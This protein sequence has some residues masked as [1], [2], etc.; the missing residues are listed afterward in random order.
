MSKVAGSRTSQSSR[1]ARSRTSTSRQENGPSKQINALSGKVNI[2]G[3]RMGVRPKQSETVII[4]SVDDRREKAKLARTKLMGQFPIVNPSSTVI[5]YMS[6]EELE[7]DEYPEITIANILN[8]AGIENI[9]LA[10]S[11]YDPLMGPYERSKRCQT[12]DAYGTDCPYHPGKILFKRPN[13]KGELIS[14]PIYRTTFLTELARCLNCICQTCGLLRLP[15]EIAEKIGLMQYSGSTRLA[16]YAETSVKIKVCQRQDTKCLVTGEYKVLKKE[17][18]VRERFSD[19]QVETVF[20]YEAYNILRHLPDE[21]A[22]A[23]GFSPY[24]KPR[25]IYILWGIPVIPPLIRPVRTIQGDKP[26][27]DDFT[28]RYAG[29]LKA[30]TELRNIAPEKVEEIY[31]DARKKRY[32]GELDHHPDI[33]AFFFN[34]TKSLAEQVDGL[35]SEKSTTGTN[36]IKANLHTTLDKKEGFI[37]YHLAGGNVIHSARTVIGPGSKMHVWEIG[38][39]EEI[40]MHLTVEEQVTDISIN[41]L[42]RWLEEGNVRSVIRDG[43]TTQILSNNRSGASKF[44]LQIGDVAYRR[45]MNGDPVPMNRNPSLHKQSMMVLYVRIIPGRKTFALPLVTTPG[46][47]ADF[48]GDEMNLHVPQSQEARAEM[49]LMSVA[50]SLE[51]V[52]KGG[53]IIGLVYNALPGLYR[54]TGPKVRIS[55]QIFSDVAM[56][57]YDADTERGTGTFKVTQMF[58]SLDDIPRYLFNIP[59]PEYFSSDLEYKNALKTNYF[60][61]CWK[62]GVKPYMGRSVIGLFLPYNLNYTEEYS[63]PLKY[64]MGRYQYES[65]TTYDENGQKT[66]EKIY[67]ITSS[68][69]RKLVNTFTYQIDQLPS[70]VVEIGREG[71]VVRRKF[72]ANQF[73]IQRRFVVRRGIIVEGSLSSGNV[74][75]GAS[76]RFL[77]FIYRHLGGKKGLGFL[78]HLNTVGNY[79]LGVDPLST[80]LIDFYDYTQEDK[81][82]AEVDK[83]IEDAKEKVLAISEPILDDPIAEEKRL[84]AVSVHLD[85]VGIKGL[86]DI[87]LR[88]EGR[89]H[90]STF[91]GGAEPG[92]KGKKENLIQSAVA[93]GYMKILG[94]PI[95]PNLIGSKGK[96][97]TPYTTHA[98]TSLSSLGYVSSCL[99]MGLSPEEQVIIQMNSRVDV[100]Q[101]KQG[102]PK[103]GYTQRRLAQLMA[104][105]VVEVDGSVRNGRHPGA[106][107]VQSCYA[108]L[109]FSVTAVY[110]HKDAKGEFFT[111]W[112]FKQML[113]NLDE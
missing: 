22:K 35:I 104:E 10:R 8:P 47:N 12:C 109:G 53:P 7:S 110:R 23:L 72:T 46:Y 76:V 18:I 29:I 89:Y 77:T 60:W 11:L 90:G 59:K 70:T 85:T 111:P 31:R 96:R 106:K 91:A 41:L 34:N 43:V 86:K 42:Q 27:I 100:A 103:T 4:P 74:G 1:I 44:I 48:D 20:P 92:A 58:H 33:E 16:K 56:N 98:S 107:I 99:A 67:R 69:G 52:A 15:P 113:L 64:F 57:L 75:H 30:S 105:L 5:R 9:N 50:E 63:T 94:R 32:D 40:A 95:E 108:E 28:E 6:R 84:E 97:I 49:F 25:D 79:Y 45:L 87:V 14:Y 81:I 2:S 54:L 55:K 66:D 62:V 38:V 102:V 51:S 112:N 26:I 83:L 39:P 21:E 17:C 37:R 61:R 101:G 78:D 68:G 93:Q 36:P 65:E 24:T 80:N 3:I 82:R 71:N 88:P 13:D 19:K 73:E